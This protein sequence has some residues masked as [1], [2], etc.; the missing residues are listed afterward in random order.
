MG[1]AKQQFTVDKEWLENLDKE[2][3]YRKGCDICNENLAKCFEGY[4]DF[5]ISIK[6]EKLVARH[7]REVIGIMDINY[8]PFCGKKL[9]KKLLDIGNA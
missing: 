7:N 1:K 2:K 3:Y 6:K 5:S 9:R 8:C 4:I